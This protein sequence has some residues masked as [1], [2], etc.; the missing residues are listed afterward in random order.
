MT[1]A[2]DTGR[3]ESPTPSLPATVFCEILNGIRDNLLRKHVSAD[4]D[5]THQPK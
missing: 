3:D 5:L 2:H 1:L 4:V